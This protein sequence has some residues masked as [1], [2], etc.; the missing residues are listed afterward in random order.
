M[1]YGGVFP[2]GSNFI[3]HRDAQLAPHLQCRQ[4][5]QHGRVGVDDVGPHL[6]GHRL[7]A[8]AQGFHEGYFA[9]HR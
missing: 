2:K 4:R 1:V 7:Q 9:A 3:H 8:L 6:P 5:I